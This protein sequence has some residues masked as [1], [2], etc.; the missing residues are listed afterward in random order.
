MTS[1]AQFEIGPNFFSSGWTDVIA[2]SSS[3]T[4]NI[5]DGSEQ[6]SVALLSLS[7]GNSSCATDSEELSSTLNSVGNWLGIWVK[8]RQGV[9]SG[10][11]DPM[12]RTDSLPLLLSRVMDVLR[13][14]LENSDAQVR[15]GMI[16]KKGTGSNPRL[17]LV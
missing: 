14:V 15:W 10:V 13:E 5:T 11:M 6:R 9:P 12:D 16:I 17:H 1:Y 2:S 3:Y 4:L 7:G 8:K